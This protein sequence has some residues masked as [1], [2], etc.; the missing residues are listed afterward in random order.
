MTYCSKTLGKIFTSPF[1]ISAKVATGK[2]TH[3]QSLED[4]LRSTS[5]FK[6]DGPFGTIYRG[7]N[8]EGKDLCVNGS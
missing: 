3:M 6:V 8:K 4:S 7:S 1:S 5:L 2:V